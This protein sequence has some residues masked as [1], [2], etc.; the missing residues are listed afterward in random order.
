[1]VRLM[2][3]FTQIRS[4]WIA[5]GI[6][7]LINLFSIAWMWHS[8]KRKNSHPKFEFEQ[9]RSANRLKNALHLNR[10]QKKMFREV[11]RAHRMEIE[12]EK[13]RLQYLKQQLS[14]MA[15]L[16]SMEEDMELL[17]SKVGDHQANI[18]R[19]NFNHLKKLFSTLDEEQQEKFRKVINS[20]A[21]QGGHTSKGRQFKRKRTIQE[22]KPRGQ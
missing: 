18:E 5:I 3:Y 20:W 10:E 11:Q 7:V 12:A 15:F 4:L 1:L 8:H 13:K 14:E 17:F 21:K 22:E 6:L 19:S 16:D 2:G 9:L